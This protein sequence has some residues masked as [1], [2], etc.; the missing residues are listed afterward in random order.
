MGRTFVIGDI[1]GERAMLERVLDRLP[2][3]A[4]D[5]TLVLLGDYVDRGP[6]A[7]GVVDRLRRLPEETAGKVV[8]LRGN[9]EDAYLR[10]LTPGADGKRELEVGFF[11]A[12][13]NG[14]AET[15]RSFTD[16]V[17]VPGAELTMDEA[18]DLFELEGWLPVAVQAWM[19]RLALWYEDDHAIY[20]HAGLDGEGAAWK[21]PRDGAER[22][23]LWMREQDFFTEYAGKPVVFGHTPVTE[24]PPHDPARAG[25][26]RRGPLWGLD[27]GAGR[28]G[29]LSAVELPAGTIYDSR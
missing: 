21:H 12:R 26:W 8:L 25:V 14:V 22:P 1:H 6:D 20:V 7:R 10:S 2:F 9:H 16:R 23:L 13:S 28:G 5:D 18:K 29:W 4:P 11:L 17:V 27:T 15:F 3:V 19:A 24:L